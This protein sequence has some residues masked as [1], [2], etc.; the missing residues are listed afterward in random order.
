VVARPRRQ[1]AWFWPALLLAGLVA[2]AAFRMWSGWATRPMVASDTVT[3]GRVTGEASD[4]AAAGRRLRLLHGRR[5]ATAARLADLRTDIATRRH[6]TRTLEEMLA[7]GRLTDC[8]P[9]LRENTTVLALQKIIR[10]A[11]GA[12]QA[13]AGRDPRLTTAAVVARERLRAKLLALHDQLDG[14]VADLEARAAVLRQKQRLQETAADEMRRRIEERLDG[15]TDG[16]HAQPAS[17]NEA[18]PA[19]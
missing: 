12:A 6:Q 17:E 4:L 13:D 18:A 10:E 15:R 19:D 8:P 7:G 16:P 5:A 2:V 11:G 9:F 14:E 3:D 1:I